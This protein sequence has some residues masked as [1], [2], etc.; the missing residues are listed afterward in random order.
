[1]IRPVR[2]C[3]SIKDEGSLGASP[4]RARGGW[5]GPR[6]ELVVVGP[7]SLIIYPESE[8][9]A[10]TVGELKEGDSLNRRKCDAD[11]R[12]CHVPTLSAH[13][14]N[15]KQVLV[16]RDARASLRT[17]HQSLCPLFGSFPVFFAL[18]SVLLR[19]SRGRGKSPFYAVQFIILYFA[20]SRVMLTHSLH[21][22]TQ[23]T[24]YASPRRITH[25]YMT[26][27]HKNIKLS[28]L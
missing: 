12:M 1:M 10:W 22:R 24:P 4:R 28:R 9:W 14:K 15:L 25:I 3:F 18:R 23:Y 11:G 21:R 13:S 8:S 19:C 17:K 20:R 6:S 27:Y 2:T 5:A 16:Y 7:A 26:T